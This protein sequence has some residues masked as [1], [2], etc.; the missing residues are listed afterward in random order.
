MNLLEIWVLYAI[1]GSTAFSA[2]F[3][4]AVRTRQFSDFDRPR[5]IPLRTLKGPDNK[6]TNGLSRIDKF[7]LLGLAIITLVVMIS[8]V[9]IGVINR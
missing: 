7:T 8:V 1:F 9:W 5:H 2:L 3:L 4:W 6:E